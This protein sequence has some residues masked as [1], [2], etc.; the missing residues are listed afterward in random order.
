MPDATHPINYSPFKNL[1]EGKVVSVFSSSEHRNMS[2]HYGDTSESLNNRKS[3]LQEL[4]I[5]YHHL[6]CAK[7]IHESSVKCV[8]E[9]DR[10]RGALSYEASVPDTDAFITD[11]K[12]LPLAIFTADCLSVFLFDP[13]LPAIGLVH[14]G[15]RSTKEEITAKSLLRMQKDFGSRI[16]DI[17]VGFGPLIRS[18]CYEVGEDF[19]KY[20][21]DGLIMKEDR[22][23]LD[24]IK[25]NKK[26]VL[27]LGVREENISDPQI[28]TS[29]RS[30]EFFS[31]RRQGKS[32]GRLMSVMMLW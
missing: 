7:Q 25:V 9:E 14:A 16:E 2:L 23:Y 26:Q 29:C 31:Y 4:G 3:F 32:C 11:K 22:F 30:Q 5:D 1:K 28:C 19:K 8:K 17:Y 18:C 24:L 20:F 13:K 27:G 15:W 21:S 6:I 12:N 10:G